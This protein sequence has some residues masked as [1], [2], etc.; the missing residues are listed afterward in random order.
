MLALYLLYPGPSFEPCAIT[1]VSALP[2]VA[3]NPG[4][5]VMDALIRDFKAKQ[6]YAL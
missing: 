5:L 2:D 6:A 1:G 3:K 4:L